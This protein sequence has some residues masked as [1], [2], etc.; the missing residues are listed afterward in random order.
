MFHFFNACSLRKKSVMIQ[1]EFA[2]K[3]LVMRRLRIGE[4]HFPYIPLATVNKAFL[5]HFILY[6]HFYS[7]SC[8]CNTH[9]HSTTFLD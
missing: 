1:L 8:I 5:E 3:T 4:R 6:C 2:I 7:V 9:L